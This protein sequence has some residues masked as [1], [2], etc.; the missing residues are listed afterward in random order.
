MTFAHIVFFANND[1]NFPSIQQMQFLFISQAR[2]A[3]GKSPPRKPLLLISPNL[4]SYF[5]NFYETQC[6]NKISLMA[7]PE[8][9]FQNVRRLQW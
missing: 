9:L 7:A 3:L 2:A 5:I 4:F 6:L 1:N 8:T